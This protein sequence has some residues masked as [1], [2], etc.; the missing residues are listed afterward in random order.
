MAWGQ[1]WKNDCTGAALR[2][3]YWKTATSIF[4]FMC[5]VCS[6]LPW[7]LM[8][9]FYSF[10]INVHHCAVFGSY[11]I[12]FIF[13]YHLDICFF[14][15][16]RNEIYFV[17][18]NLNSKM[19]CIYDFYLDLQKVITISTL[20]IKRMPRFLQF[21]WKLQNPSK[22]WSSAYSTLLLNRENYFLRL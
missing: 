21:R 4:S 8:I 22:I 14:V 17:K 6:M 11:Q 10:L 20:C 7:L 18:L 9:H 3:H 15:C 13:F 16:N 19:V 1:K 2:S 12:W 5:T